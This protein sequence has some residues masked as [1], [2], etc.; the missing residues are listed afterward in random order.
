M[1]GSTQSQP[2]DFSK[3]L[4]LGL[5]P[6]LVLGSIL[7]TIALHG[8]P[9][10]TSGWWVLL[11]VVVWSHLTHSSRLPPS[12]PS[13]LGGPWDSTLF[14][15]LTSALLIFHVQSFLPLSAPTERFVI[16]FPMMRDRQGS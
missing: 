4:L 9:I 8:F 15:A 14:P 2:T 5:P 10:A 13:M 11:V 16:S 1:T 12:D 7:W 3:F 6:P